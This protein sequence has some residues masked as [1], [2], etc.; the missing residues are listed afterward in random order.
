MRS[1]YFLP[2]ILVFFYPVA[3]EKINASYQEEKPFAVIAY[4]SGNAE[5]ID[6]FPI[7]KLTHIIFSFG[8]LKGNQL[9]IDNARDSAT[10][11][12]LVLLKKRNPRLKVILSLGGWG[13][14]KTCSPVFDMDT[15]RKEFASSVKKLL[16]YFKADG[17]DLDWEYPAIE[18]YPG[19]AFKLE[20]RSNFTMLVRALRDSLGAEKEISFAAGGFDKFLVESVEWEKVMP[21]LDKVNL[22]S[23]D[24]VGGY[25]KV[26]GHH[27][28]LYTTAE[29]KQSADNAIRYLDS[30]QVPLNKI[31]IGAA[32]YARVWD[33]VGSVNN[34]LYQPGVF[35]SFVPYRNFPSQITIRQGYTFYRD[36]VAQAPYAYNAKKG[37]FATFDDA[38]SIAAKTRYA[39]KMGLGGIMFWELSLD[40]KTQGLVSVIDKVK[41]ENN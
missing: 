37:L 17:I 23:Y 7:E 12:K 39:K 19:H 36:S 21:L 35:K 6:Q 28:P 14:C 9:S 32:F 38:V 10:I 3:L 15:G 16:H 13:G 22:M 30:I 27:T 41:R 33:S 26:T 31:I 18:G 1:R 11:R 34:G 29:Q 20:D 8:H 40:T 2:A 25:S 24:L 5:E 4:Y